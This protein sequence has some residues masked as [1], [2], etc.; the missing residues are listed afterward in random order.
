MLRAVQGWQVLS[1]SLRQGSLIVDVHAVRMAPAESQHAQ[2]DGAARG[3]EQQAAGSTAELSSEQGFVAYRANVLLRQVCMHCSPTVTFC[4]CR[5]TTCTGTLAAGQACSPTV[6]LHLFCI[7]I[8]HSCQGQTLACEPLT[9]VP[10]FH[11]G[12]TLLLQITGQA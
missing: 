1:V 7:C 9:A 6:C 11:S 3:W 10:C 12:F 2:H 8:L 5:M 4:S